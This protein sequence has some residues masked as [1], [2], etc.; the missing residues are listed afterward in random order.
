MKN[1]NEDT[2]LIEDFLQ[3]S[4][5]KFTVEKGI[6]N[7]VGIYCCPWSGWLTTNFNLDK[8]ILEFHSN[9][10]DFQ[11]S[12]FDLLELSD[13]Q[14]EYEQES[15][16]FIINGIK[17]KHDHNLGDEGLNELIFNFL[18]PVVT[19]IKHNNRSEFLLQL[20]DSNFFAIID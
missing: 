3:R 15:P 17:F 5:D 1:L 16:L 4:I 11:Y 13:W 20:L 9:C 14:E 18:K 2:Q 8:S 10:P 19:G 6:P 7:S 12:E